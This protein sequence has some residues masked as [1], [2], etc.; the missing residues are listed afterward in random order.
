MTK[1]DL[2][3]IGSGPGGYRAAQYAA[4]HGLEVII[5]EDRQA[6]GTCLNEGCIPTKCLVHDSL[7]GTPFE[8]AMLRKEE[9]SAQL[10]QGVEILMSQ[11][12]VTMVK[13]HARITAPRHCRGRNRD[14]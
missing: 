13:A 9:V 12:H 14:L 11:P 5:F 7:K 1:T 10:R 3:I 6:G 8:Q 4:Q 2:I